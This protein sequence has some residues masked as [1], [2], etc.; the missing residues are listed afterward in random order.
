VWKCNFGKEKDFWNFKTLWFHEEGKE[1]GEKEKEK[2]N[3]FERIFSLTQ[4]I[5]ILKPRVPGS[6]SK[7]R[8]SSRKIPKSSEI[9]VSRNDS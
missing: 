2:E 7:V 4:K 3:K 9:Q 5:I 6:K 8:E 1:N